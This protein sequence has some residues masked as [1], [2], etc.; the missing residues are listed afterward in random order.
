MP[1]DVSVDSSDK[2]VLKNKIKIVNAVVVAFK[3]HPM[4]LQDACGRL[5]QYIADGYVKSRQYRSRRICG[6]KF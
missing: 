6:N 5:N 2:F 4:R 3:G 1:I